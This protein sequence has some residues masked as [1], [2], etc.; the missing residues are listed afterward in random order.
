MYSIKIGITLKDSFE[1]R[2][3]L[4]NNGF[5][6]LVIDKYTSEPF[7]LVEDYSTEERITYTDDRFNCIAVLNSPNPPK[8]EI[9]KE[10]ENAVVY[11]YTLRKRP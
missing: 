9:L 3:K 11:E 5:S 1:L 2:Q 7:T 10:L 8:G 6:I 4:Y